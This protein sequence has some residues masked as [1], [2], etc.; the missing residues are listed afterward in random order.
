VIRSLALLLV[1]A[2]LPQDRRDVKL[3][4]RSVTAGATHSCGIA[5]GGV[6]YCWGD[7]GFG[8]LGTGDERSSLVPF[9]EPG[10]DRVVVIVFE[11]GRPGWR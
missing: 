2:I 10:V 7:N 5:S 1:L 4:Y 8:Q 3:V 6:A 11:V 9:L